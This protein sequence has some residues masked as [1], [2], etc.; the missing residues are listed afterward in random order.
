V[1]ARGLDPEASLANNDAYRALDA[2]GALLRPGP[3]HTNVM[4][5]QVAMV[6]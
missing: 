3:T 4:D 6:R 2:A 5:V 1:R